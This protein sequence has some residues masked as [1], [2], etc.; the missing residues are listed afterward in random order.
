MS[1]RLIFRLLIVGVY[2]TS[3]ELAKHWFFKHF[4]D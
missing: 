2:V 3:A 1:R 4:K